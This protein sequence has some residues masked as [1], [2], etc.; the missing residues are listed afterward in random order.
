M[1]NLKDKTAAIF[2]ETIDL[3]SYPSCNDFSGN[4]TV[5]R[6]GDLA[7][8][9]SYKGQPWQIRNSSRWDC[10]NVYEILINGNVCQAFKHNL[11]PAR[12][13]YSTLLKGHDKAGK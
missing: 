10:Y 7:T 8:V 6:H 3:C 13:S 11:E 1:N 12:A 4:E 9:L 2:Y 5:V